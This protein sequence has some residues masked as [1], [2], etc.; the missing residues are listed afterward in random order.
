[1]DGPKIDFQVL[2]NGFD[3]V[4]G[5]G[6][7]FWKPFD[8]PCGDV[9]ALGVPN[10]KS[11]KVWADVEPAMSSAKSIKREEGIRIMQN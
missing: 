2:N 8:I 5:C 4:D 3:A 6:P 7:I 10:S 11:S 9:K 1:M